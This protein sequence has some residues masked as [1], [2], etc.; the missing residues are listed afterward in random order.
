VGTDS[1]DTSGS[2]SLPIIIG[3]IAGVVV[4]AAAAA[5][6]TQAR[7][8]KSSGDQKMFDSADDVELEYL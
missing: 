1:D 2:S 4:L 8:G 3:V 7:K 6:I 5:A